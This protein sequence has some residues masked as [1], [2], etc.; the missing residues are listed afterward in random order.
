[1]QYY[2]IREKNTGLYFRGKGVNRWGEHFNQATIYRVKGVAEFSC[3]EINQRKNGEEAEIVPIQ[4]IETSAE[5]AEVKH[6]YWFTDYARQ[7]MVVCSNCDKSN[8]YNR[9]KYCPH[10]GARM[11]G[12]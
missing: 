6:G 3:K 4:I 12:R 8:N 7:P 1:M 5:V 9:S 11:D 2:V 10:C